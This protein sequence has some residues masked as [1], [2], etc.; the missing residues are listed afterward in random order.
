[1][2]KDHTVYLLAQVA[3]ATAQSRWLDASRMMDEVP[4]EWGPFS[5]GPQDSTDDETS[6]EVRSLDEKRAIAE[7]ARQRAIGA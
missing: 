7:R 6:D 1:M 4:V 5:F 3:T 2:W